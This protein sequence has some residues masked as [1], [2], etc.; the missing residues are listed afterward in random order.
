MIHLQPIRAEDADLLFPLVNR[1]PI[2][3]TLAWDGPKSLDSFR[4]D[5]GERAQQVERGERHI[6]SM[7]DPQS[8][9]P[10]GSAD[11]RPDDDNFRADL[12]LWI[13]Q[14]YHSRG[15][16]TAAVH[17]LVTYGFK[18]LNLEKIEARVF[19]GNFASRRIF[20]KNGFALEGTIRKALQKRGH[21][22]DEWLF[23]LTRE[24]YLARQPQG[25]DLQGV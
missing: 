19:C 20:E 9:S 3:D 18:T 22:V 4:S 17:W 16:G 5:L 25:A 24:D 15:Y 6:F 13:G 21:P 12:G 23:G 2:T 8:G 10:I 11:I 14:P 1:T 7:I